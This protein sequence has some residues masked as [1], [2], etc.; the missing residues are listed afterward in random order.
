VKPHREQF[1]AAAL[2]RT[3]ST[4]PRGL[5]F[6]RLPERILL[7]N[8]LARR[9]AN[10]GTHARLALHQAV[11]FKTLDGLGDGQKAHAEF[12]RQLSSRQRGT[13]GILTTQDFVP[14]RLVR[15]FRQTVVRAESA[16]RT[17]VS[18]HDSSSTPNRPA[19]EANSGAAAS[20]P[21]CHINL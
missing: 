20:N 6:E 14:D 12:L 17:Q 13:E 3:F 11:Y 7:H 2:V 10:P 4:Q 9:H 15:S 5:R 19:A 1:L 16:G 18:Q 21:N 8:V